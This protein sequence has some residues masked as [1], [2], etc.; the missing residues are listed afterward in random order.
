MQFGAC[1]Q[2]SN[3]LVAQT[4]GWDFIE[5]NVQSFFKGQSTDWQAPPAVALPVPS[6]NSL[7]PATLPI[8]GPNVDAAALRQYMTNVITRAQQVQMHTLVFGS[9]GARNVP[10]GFDRNKAVDQITAFLA[11]AGPIAQQ[12]GVTLVIEPLNRGECN[13]LNSV[14]E[15]MT[16]VK[17]LNHP[18]VKCLVD[19]Y[20][21]W[22]EDEPLSNL[23]AAMPDIYHV[24]V[25]D[26][27]ERVAPGESGKSDYLSF[28]KVLKAGGY[29]KL[30]AVE[31]RGFDLQ[32]NGPRSLKFLQDN[33]AKA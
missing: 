29:D 26:K 4:G 20:H 28:F 3:A 23:E 25:A 5:E 9:G 31:C 14:A 11:M 7:V 2:S 1:I 12:H 18:H 16:Y 33:W 27:E 19:S 6:A 30:I 21:M 32:T 8:V 15:A 17:R 10:D 22:L 24:H 13:I